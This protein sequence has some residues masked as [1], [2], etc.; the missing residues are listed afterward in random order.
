M[1][2]IIQAISDKFRPYSKYFIIII[3]VILFV[4]VGYY[5]YKRY[6][7]PE[8]IKKEK[9]YDDIANRPKNGESN[10][11]EIMF[12]H[13]NWCPHCKKCTPD[14]EMFYKEYNAQTVNGYNIKCTDV[15]CTNEDDANVNSLLSKYKVEGY[16]TVIALVDDRQIAF[17]AKVTKENLEQ[18][19]GELTK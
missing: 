13:A 17:D 3:S 10:V 18:F 2:T 14:W 6:A 15:D 19:V 12:F 9:G 5:V 7:T 1:P 16:P 4:S 11:V 8:V